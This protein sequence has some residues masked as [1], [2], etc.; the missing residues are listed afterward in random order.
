MF[1]GSN[2][3]EKE[4]I[5]IVNIAG[6]DVVS[7][8]VC[9]EQRI[10][11]RIEKDDS[12][13]S[14]EEEESKEEGLSSTLLNSFYTA[15]GSPMQLFRGLSD[16][17][18]LDEIDDEDSIYG[19]NSVSSTESF[20]PK[21]IDDDFIFGK[22]GT[23]SL[24]FRVATVD[25]LEFLDVI[26]VYKRGFKYAK[27]KNQ[28]NV[29][30]L[31]AGVKHIIDGKALAHLIT[32]KSTAYVETVNCDL[33]HEMIDYRLNGKR[34]DT[35]G[36]KR[37]RV[38][39]CPDPDDVDGTKF[40]THEVMVEKCQEPSR[41]WVEAGS[42]N[43]G[44]VKVEILSCEGLPNKDIVRLFGNKTDPFVSLVYEDCLVQTDRLSDCLSPMWMPWTQRAFVFNR[45]HALSSIYI[46]VFNH[47]IGP[48]QHHGCGRVTVDLREFQPNTVY[49][50]KYELFSSPVLTK[51]K[52]RMNQ[53][54][55][56]PLCSSYIQE[57]T[58]HHFALCH[59]L[60]AQLPLDY[61][62]RIIT[63]RILYFPSSRLL[64]FMST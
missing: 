44:Q 58:T 26:E 55:S 62:Y 57:S 10:H 12:S 40:L 15:A 1:D 43:L 31:S 8:D 36:V 6:K 51:R 17:D 64:L 59:S 7:D 23:L 39:P 4:L 63:T 33:V 32:E 50:L 47:V 21:D 41:S 61:K 49:T 9:N 28:N 13:D 56:N 35:E 52:V 53:L 30:T 2:K 29:Q 60:R 27:R 54:T 46:G 24:R 37:L 45:M 11:R 5:G 3:N 14:D 20:S 22:D 25:D 34:V 38:K 18:F 48:Y 42:G 16:T 19:N